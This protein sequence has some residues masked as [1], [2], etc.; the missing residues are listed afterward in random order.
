MPE[1]QFQSA[2]QMKAHY[3]A[4]NN[5]MLAAGKTYSQEAESRRRAELG[6]QLRLKAEKQARKALMAMEAERLFREAQAEYRRAMRERMGRL[7]ADLI[8]EDVAAECGL[9]P[10]DIVGP[11]VRAHIVS[12]RWRAVAEV[13]RAWPE[14]SL[15][16]LGK[17]FKRDHTTILNALRKMGVPTR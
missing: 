6:R 17:I 14:L 5:R 3:R 13:K 11:S 9:T 10:A 16:V 15:P 12:A 4:V 8:I 7:S 1:I 2:E